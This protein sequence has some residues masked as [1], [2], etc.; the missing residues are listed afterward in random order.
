MYEP[1]NVVIQS[2]INKDAPVATHFRPLL[3]SGSL[4]LDLT[5]KDNI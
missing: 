2:I 3:R 5:S 1:T 4:K